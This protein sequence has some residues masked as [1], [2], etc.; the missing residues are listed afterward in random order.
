MTR[1][2]DTHAIRIGR[3]ALMAAVAFILA[4][5]PAIA[6]ETTGTIKG[7]IVDA[8][9]LA[10]PGVTVTATGPQGA[11]TTVSDADG[12]F[13]LPF[14]TPGTYA[15][16]AELQGFKAVER[17]AVNVS[18]GQAVD[19]TALRME[20]GGLTET[21]QVTAAS[22]IVDT[23]T[24]TTGAVLDS[25]MLQRVPVGRRVSD[26]LYMAPGVSTSGS[27]GT[28]NPSISGGSGLDNQY[29][30]DGVNVTNQGY[31]ALGSYSIIF[32]SLGNA[33]PFDFVKE[34]QVKTGGYE[35]E[36]GQSTG[37]VVN[38]ITKSGS[39][40]LRG[41]GFAYARPSGVEGDWVH[42][43]SVNGTLQ[44][45]S[46]HLSDFG[47]EGGGPIVKNR[48]FFFGAVDPQWDTRT[49]HAPQGFPLESL[50]D[51]DRTRRSITYSAKGTFQVSNA[52]R[53]DASFFGDPSKADNGPQ[54]GNSL[55]A[56]DTSRFSAL[57]Y[58]GHNQTVRYDGVLSAKWLLEGYFARALNTINET[59][60]VDQWNVTDTTV[61]PNIL[62]GGIGLYES[63][64][65]VN[66]QYSIK[67][68]NIL[69]GHQI[70]YGFEYDDVSYT[71]GSQRT[72][73]TFTAPNGRQTATGASVSI[74]PD[75]SFGRIYRVTRA[76]F[77]AGK[78]TQQRYQTFFAQDSWK[79]TDRLTL[80][81]GVRYEQE[82][83]DGVLIKDFSLKNN[84]APR[85]GATYDLTG[86]G[87]TKV[88]GN[89]GRFYARIP[90]D[91]AARALSA[92]DG[93]SRADYFDANLSRPIPNGTVTRTPTGAAVTNHFVPAG[94]FP[95]TIDPNAK[96]SFLDEWVGG[97]E[98]E[99]LPNTTLGV[100]YIHK[101]IG[102]VFED[103]ANCPVVAY[104]FSAA[105][106]SACGSVEYIL[107][108]PTSAT[109]INPDLLAVAPQFGSVHFDDPIHK[110]DAVE[111][112]LN[113]RFSGHWSAL[114]SYRWS[115]LRGNF[116]GFFRDDNGQSDPGITSLYDFP[117]N[118]PTYAGIGV[119]LFGYQGDI[120]FLGQNGILPLDRPHQVKIFG[121]YAWDSGLS[122]GVGYTGT[123]GKPLTGLAALAPYD[124]GGE[125]PTTARGAGIQTVDGFVTRTPFLNEF[126]AQAAYALKMGGTNRL[127]LMADVFNVFS[128]STVLDY[129]NYVEFP[130]FGTA[131]PDF[132]KP[133]SRNVAGPQ[134]QTPRQIR[135]GIRY[136]F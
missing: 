101:N 100:R 119:P 98:R 40:E 80:N 109:P 21:I 86:D 103:V 108:N 134:F 90:N 16:R 29:V 23:T 14:L 111:L 61:S 70:K 48:A 120:R 75:V 41:S 87:K 95:D 117:T 83:L 43:Q 127:T 124:N 54:R 94:Q 91:L 89:F 10:V 12:R 17:G 34:V 27:A 35:A 135:F 123:S 76:N 106:Q 116:E 132:G 129:N 77:N 113:R 46:T 5:M 26:T 68:T 7:R 6:Q 121:N 8:Q 25:E 105:T 72:G 85:L 67:S 66:N 97:V 59:P 115:R 128:R 42:Y 81:L 28:A 24:T 49:F 88:Y 1:N 60:S 9:G 62:T 39:N 99:V 122:L 45:Q 38:V 11:K 130:G 126:N 82:T 32:G 58:G 131:D 65:S 125:I 64:R 136:E 15:V 71:Q 44:T 110:Y 114:T 50:G 56:V 69:S 36:F 18:L 2:F 112:T 20:V 55:T 22:P 19:L 78:D 84:W 104:D 3:T 133:I 51:V 102:R 96:L 93:I 118:D 31:G 4:V 30:V 73:P 53:I 52:H 47:A 107:T 74:L 92:D 79:A 33:T 57:D 37:G 13:S 63:N